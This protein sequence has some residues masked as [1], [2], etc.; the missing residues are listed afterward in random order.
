MLKR[1]A[2]SIWIAAT[3]TLIF[4]ILGSPVT[5]EGL[6]EM[7]AADMIADLTR[8]VKKIEPTGQE[9]KWRRIPWRIDLMAARDEAASENKPIFLWL[10]NGHPMGC[11]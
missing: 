7:N 1:I 5:A 8:K 3:S 4:L 11:T 10:M 6:D 9:E 2:S